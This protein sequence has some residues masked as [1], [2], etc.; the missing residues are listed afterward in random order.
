VLTQNDFAT[1]WPIIQNNLG[2]TLKEFGKRRRSKALLEEAVTAMT[3]AS[4]A[5]KEQGKK[6][7]QEKAEQQIEDVLQIIKMFGL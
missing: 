7:E 3:E 4:R 1:L 2:L 6:A 5:W